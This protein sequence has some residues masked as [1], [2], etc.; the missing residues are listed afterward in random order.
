MM[1]GG[2]AVKVGSDTDGVET[3][4]LYLIQ[5]GSLAAVNELHDSGEW[6]DLEMAVFS[7]TTAATVVAPEITWHFTAMAWAAYFKQLEVMQ[8]LIEKGAKVNETREWH[9]LPSTAAS[10]VGFI[11]GLELLKEKGCDLTKSGSDGL[12][13]VHNAAA[14]GHL[15]VLH[16]LYSYECSMDCLDAGGMNA[17]HHAT[18][19]SNQ[20][21]IQ[22]LDEWNVPLD[23]EDVHG[24]TAADYADGRGRPECADLIRRLAKQRNQCHRILQEITNAIEANEFTAAHHLFRSDKGQEACS[25][26]KSAFAPVVQALEQHSTMMADSWIDEEG[27]PGTGAG[28]QKK[29]KKKSEDS[30]SSSK[31]KAAK[32]E[33]A[34][35][36]D[37][38]TLIDMIDRRLKGTDDDWSSL[39][40]ARLRALLVHTSPGA[41]VSE[42]RIKGIKAA[43]LE[44]RVILASIESGEVMG[45]CICMDGVADYVLVH[46]NTGHQCVC[47]A[48]AERMYASSLPCN[49]CRQTIDY[50][51]TAALV[52]RSQVTVYHDEQSAQN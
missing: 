7:T 21:I 17:A 35:Q 8:W 39:S 43:V 19:N 45:C 31:K 23:K 4:I 48:C 52:D 47:K 33:P 49:I 13:P 30:S 25:K 36:L 14:G 50:V 28:G 51:Q 22:Q 12:T 24:H 18:Q 5:T 15:P 32:D 37:D 2:K 38:D 6:T 40:P 42:K 10:R 26:M 44:H 3:D 46:G 20:N 41:A 11:E 1:D 27:A 34:I 9:W 16:L 29:G